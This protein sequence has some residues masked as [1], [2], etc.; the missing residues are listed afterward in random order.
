MYSVDVFD[1]DCTRESTDVRMNGITLLHIVY[2]NGQL[3]ATA[4][5]LD[6][7]IITVSAIW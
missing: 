2:A 6:W 3:S 4:I 5:S 1:F 7:P